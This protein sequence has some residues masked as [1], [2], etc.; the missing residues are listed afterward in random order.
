MNL[1]I[2]KSKE[3]SIDANKTEKK[4]L[5]Y[6]LMNYDKENKNLS[7][8]M[9]LSKQKKSWEDSDVSLFNNL[10]LIFPNNPLIMN[11]FRSSQSNNNKKIHENKK[12]EI[13]I[14]NSSEIESKSNLLE[15]KKIFTSTE[16]KLKESN[17]NAKFNNSFFK[18]N[19]KDQNLI[20]LN[21]EEMKS[22]QSFSEKCKESFDFTKPF[23]IKN[24]IK[25]PQLKNILLSQ[26]K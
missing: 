23:M 6:D 5:N 1:D 22:I 4:K 21:S 20:S 10:N 9:K 13:L 2:N 8:L 14:K 18:N 12:N 26:D 25:S 24:D 3:S 16:N 17:L 15:I 11:F 19:L 7:T